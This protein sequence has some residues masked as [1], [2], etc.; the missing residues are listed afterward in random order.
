MRRKRHHIGAERA[1]IEGQPASDLNRVGVQKTARFV[2]D[3][4]CRGDRLDGAGL[5]VG[6]HQRNEGPPP[7]E[8]VFGKLR[9]KHIEVDNAIGRHGNSARASR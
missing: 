1:E 7:S 5:V 8:M 3:F 2:D 9:R 6:R 4:G